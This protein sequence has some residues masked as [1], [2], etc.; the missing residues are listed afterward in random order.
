MKRFVTI[1][2]SSIALF[3][4]SGAGSSGD[5]P[6]GTGT[7]AVPLRGPGAGIGAGTGNGNGAGTGGFRLSNGPGAAPGGQAP[8]GQG[9]GDSF[10]AG[11][12]PAS[13]PMKATKTF[14]ISSGV[15][16]IQGVEG[17]SGGQ[18]PGH[19]YMGMNKDGSVSARIATST[20]MVNELNCK[21][22]S[23]PAAMA[24]LR[25]KNLKDSG[26][27]TMRRVGKNK[28]VAREGACTAEG[29]KGPVEIRFLDILRKDNEG[30]W[31][32]AAIV[33]YPKDAS[34][35][36]KNEAMAW[37]RSLE[38]NGQNGYTMP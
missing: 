5:A 30:L 38:Y 24:P 35:E 10:F 12:P 11:D 33:G 1:V 15:L 3:G 23:M 37:A 36:M 9:A 25:A 19:D 28:F 22:L 13:V 7:A 27:V 20:A 32:Y 4:C 14:A 26:P 16:M 2:V 31:H 21:E 34:P 29:P 18:L 6:A 17:W 8:G